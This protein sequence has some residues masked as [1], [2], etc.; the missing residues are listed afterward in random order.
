MRFLLS[1]FVLFLA[2][3]GATPSRDA[4][5]VA[6]VAQAPTSQRSSGTWPGRY[7]GNL[8]CAD[9]PGLEVELRLLTG[10]RYQLDSHRRDSPDTPTTVSGHFDWTFDG[11]H[12]QLDATGAHAFFAIGDGTLL[13]RNADGTWPRGL[14]AESMTLRREP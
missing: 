8:P 4:G 14:Q 2:A 9:C 10:D 11:N 1:A 3:C 13:Q 7:R 6:A 5:D 12:I